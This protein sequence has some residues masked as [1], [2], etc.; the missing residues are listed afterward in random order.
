MT[1]AVMQAFGAEVESRDGLIR[2]SAESKY[3]GRDYQIEPDASAGSYFWAAAAI[4]GGRARVL[5]LHRNSL[6]GDVRFCDVL[7][8][9]GCHVRYES[10]AIEVCGGELRGV[11]VNMKD[12]SDTVQSLAAVAV[13]ARGPTTIRGVAHNR[14][15]ETDRIADLVRELRKV[16]AFVEEFEDGLRI[17]PTADVKPA[18]F[19][20]YQD[21]R[22]AMSLALIGLRVPGVAVRNPD[23][24]AKT[25]PGYW[26]DLETFSGCGIE[27]FD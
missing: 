16:G 2:V 6:Q 15:K 22:M 20:T 23:C 3:V 19:E 24:T 27:R 5:G 17:A 21:H 18:E 10:D 1:Q 4:T 8:K 9:M 12:I 13:F 7:A 14:V 26:R 11:D 25:Y